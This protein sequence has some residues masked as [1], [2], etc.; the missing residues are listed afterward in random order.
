MVT[1]HEVEA[2]RKRVQE[3][4]RHKSL[5]KVI[6][7]EKQPTTSNEPTQAQP[8]QMIGL[9]ATIYGKGKNKFTELKLHHH[10]KTYRAWTNVNFHHMEGFS[11][12]RANGREYFFLLSA[13]TA[14]N[15]K[16]KR[17]TAADAKKA[18]CPVRRLRKNR[19]V[20]V[21]TGKHTPENAEAR[22][23]FHDL[24]TLYRKEKRQL[25]SAYQLRKKNAA[26][27]LAKRADE[28]PPRPKDITI[29]FWKRDVP[30]ERAEAES[31]QRDLSERRAK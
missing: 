31:K 7:L 23:I 14:S 16:G 25:V 24:H 19:P 12:F 8:M 10:E 1:L 4:P 21:F 30:K 13:T 20:F 9:E 22:E 5:Q 28:E 15:D 29:H 6:P 17:L 26:I 11:A 3:T 18:G 27:R 2:P